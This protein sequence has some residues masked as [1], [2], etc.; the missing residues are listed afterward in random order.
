MFDKQPVLRVKKLLTIL[1]LCRIFHS[2]AQLPTFS[3]QTHHHYAQAYRVIDV[4]QTIFCATPNGF[5]SYNTST[6]TFKTYSKLNGLTDGP[7]TAMTYLS[8]RN[9]L[10]VAYQ[11]GG[12]DLLEL[13]DSLSITNAISINFIKNTTAIQTSKKIQ[14]LVEYQGLLF[15]AADFG[16]GIIDLKTSEIKE[17]YQRIGENGKQIGIEKIAFRNDSIF[18]KT[19]EGIRAAYYTTSTNLAYYGNWKTLPSTDLFQDNVLP[20]HSLITQPQES[21]QT[22]EGIYW[23][24]DSKNGLLSNWEGDF[25]QYQ[26]NGLSEVTGFLRSDNGNVQFVGTNWWE[27]NNSFWEKKEGTKPIKN[28]VLTDFYGN[29]WQIQGFYLL[30]SNASGTYF[31]STSDNLPGTPQALALA[32]D[33]QLWVA[34]SNG[35]GVIATTA[36]IVRTPV[37]AYLPVFGNQRLL[38]QQNVTSVVVDTGG[39]KWFGTSNG[40]YFFDANLEKLVQYFTTTNAPFTTNMV[41]S[42]ALS[43]SGELFVQTSDGIYSY[44]TDATKPAEEYTDVRIYPNPV[45]PDFDGV[46][47]I[48]GLLENS[49]IKITTA[50]GVALTTLTSNGGAVS[51]NMQDTTGQRVPTGIYLIFVLSTDSSERFIG[52]V[53]IVK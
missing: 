17:T 53:A 52:K 36:D 46:L 44:Q 45:R 15:F 34:T 35:V 12:I 24:A 6:K 18:V 8:E 13:D 37:R 31:Y 1:L 10:A 21:I 29:K 27:Y 23:I 33:G 22:T 38:L 43:N 4:N 9:Q 42:L 19:T 20:N 16:L 2:A 50:S 3:W 11:S 7:I 48:N 14:E 39:R 41:E 25:R 49:L 32:A 30:V 5:F 47:T 28:T 26:P 40:L 51:W